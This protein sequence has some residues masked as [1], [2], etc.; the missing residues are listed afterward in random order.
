MVSF[1]EV[2]LGLGVA[3]SM[4]HYSCLGWDLDCRALY[5][6]DV[7]LDFVD[8]VVD[9]VDVGLDGEHYDPLHHHHTPT[10]SRRVNCLY[11]S[12]VL[13]PEKTRK[14]KGRVNEGCSSSDER[15]K[16]RVYGPPRHKKR[17]EHE[18]GA[19]HERQEWKAVGVPFHL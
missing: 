7:A 9:F 15:G 16:N 4:C 6:I 17:L 3:K 5:N 1:E 13:Y 11:A 19:F 2:Q 8:V 18:N 10:F 12:P 14:G